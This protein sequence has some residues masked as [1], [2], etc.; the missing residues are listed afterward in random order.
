MSR[1]YFITLAYLFCLTLFACAPTQTEISHPTIPSLAYTTALKQQMAQ[2]GVSA[3]SS[4]ETGWPKSNIAEVPE[5]RPI[6]MEYNDEV[7]A[8]LHYVKDLPPEERIPDVVS[9]EILPA[10]PFGT[11][12]EVHRSQ[13]PNS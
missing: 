7:R 5:V 2:Q 9:N 13:I 8:Q 12:V 1:K 10:A 3:S 4:F 11:D 6:H